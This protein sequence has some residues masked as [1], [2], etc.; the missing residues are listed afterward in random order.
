MGLFTK[1]EKTPAATVM[2]DVLAVKKNESVLIIANP[3]TNVIA[4]QLYTASLEVGA[5]PVLMFQQKKA[6][7]DSA[8]KAIIGAL[9]SE[10]DIVCSISSGKL[11]KDAE[12]TAKPY[13]ALD[14]TT[15]D[16]MF[17]LLLEGKKC[18]RA[19]W[20]PGLTEDMFNRT[21][22]I[23]YKLLNEQCKKI[24]KR[25]ENA[26]SVHVTSPNGT[27]VVVPVNNRK[28][29]ADNG[30]FSKA[31]SG[32]NIPAGEVFISPVVGGT[33]IVASPKNEQNPSHKSMF[34]AMNEKLMSVT[35]LKNTTEEAT[36]KEQEET[37]K[38][39][40]TD[41][42]ETEDVKT[43]QNAEG[44]SGVIV[45]D[46]SMSFN[47]G[48]AL[49]ENP[50]TVKVVNGFVDEIT[51]GEEAR[52]LLKDITT[53]EK[54]SIAMETAGKLAEGQGAIYSRNARNIGELGIGL[55]PNANITGNMLEDEKAFRTCHFAIGR[56]YDGDAPALIH[57]DGIVRNPTIVIKY[58]NGS[59]YTIMD[60][61]DLKL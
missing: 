57:F 44:T 2:E 45:F 5:K 11:G 25:Y 47:D 36:K 33:P 14:G 32:G 22:N 12:G 52:R 51:G 42:N 6:S 4:Q 30:D 58:E 49:L 7:M 54:E 55:N 39:Q 60:K 20:T 1:K 27:D 61:G 16:N 23:D 17:D 40:S 59:E 56:N 3:E 35:K 50:I 31:G 8:E 34:N 13:T 41:S 43:E 10:P 48:D 53:A 28:P 38:S 19:I 37:E 18:T 29:M 26:V 46:G 15:Y 21:V 9:S 24:F